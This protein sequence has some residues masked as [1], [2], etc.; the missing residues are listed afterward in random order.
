M[1]YLADAMFLLRHFQAFG[2]VR[3]TIS[4]IKKRSSG[5]ERAIRELFIEDEGIQVG[6]PL[7]SF[8]G[9]L[10]GGPQYLGENAGLINSQN[11]A[12]N[13]TPTTEA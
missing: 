10:S 3:L 9:I 7:T 8:H 5:H 2:T 1:S 4:I 6:P 12:S 11:P 13:S